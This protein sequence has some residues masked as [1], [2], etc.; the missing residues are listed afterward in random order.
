MNINYVQTWAETNGAF[1]SNQQLKEIVEYLKRLPDEKQSQIDEIKGFRPYGLIQILSIFCLDRFA[2]GDYI[3]GI[4]KIITFGGFLIAWI[5][6][7][8]H[9]RNNTWNYNYAVFVRKATGTKI[10]TGMSMKDLE[11]MGKELAPKLREIKQS[12]KNFQDS[13]YI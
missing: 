7:M 12:T 4:I 11:K 5:K 2:L 13:L 10:K 3:G 8:I 6:D 1:F 9:A